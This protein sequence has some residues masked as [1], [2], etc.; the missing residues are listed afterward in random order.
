MFGYTEAEAMGR[1]VTMLIPPERH[2]EEDEIMARLNRGDRLGH[3]ETVRLAKGGRRIEV[4]LSVSPIKDASGKVIWRGQDSARHHRA[5]DRGAKFA[6][7]P[8]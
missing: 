7:G 1:P 5:Q 4:S 2:A 3:Y 6:A 8:E